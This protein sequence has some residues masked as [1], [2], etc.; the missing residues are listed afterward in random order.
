[1]NKAPDSGSVGY[2]A[3]AIGADMAFGYFDFS[4]AAIRL[5][6]SAWKAAPRLEIIE[7]QVASPSYPA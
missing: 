2:S 5:K 7:R 3:Y 6:K 1:M 4:N